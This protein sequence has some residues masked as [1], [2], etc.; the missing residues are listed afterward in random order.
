MVREHRLITCLKE[1]RRECSLGWNQCLILFSLQL[2]IRNLSQRAVLEAWKERK[3][4]S[5]TREIIICKRTF[6][7]FNRLKILW[8]QII[9]SIFRQIHKLDKIRSRAIDT[10][11]FPQKTLLRKLGDINLPLAKEILWL[12]LI[13]IKKWHQLLWALQTPCLK[14]HRIRHLIT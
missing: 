5:S 6:Q 12:P 10:S 3:L 2:L 8:A 4:L 13:S 7:R 1:R 9:Q 14:S 11:L